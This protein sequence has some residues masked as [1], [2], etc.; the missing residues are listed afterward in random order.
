MI[1]FV[2]H[3]VIV[4]IQMAVIRAIVNLAMKVMVLSVLISM[5]VG[6]VARTDWKTSGPQ[7]RSRLGNPDRRRDDL[8]KCHADYG[9]CTNNV[10]SYE[11]DCISGYTGD[12]IFC[13]DVDE[14]F[15]DTDECDTDVGICHNTQGS[16]YC[17]CPEG[18]TGNGVICNDVDECL[19]VNHDCDAFATCHNDHGVYTCE[20][21]VGYIGNGK[22]CDDVDECITGDH[23]CPLKTI[24][25]NNDGSFNCDCDVGYTS[26]GAD[27]TCDGGNCVGNCVDIDEC[28]L[29]IDTCHDRT[30]CANTD[31][32][33]DFKKSGYIYTASR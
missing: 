4:E 13:D 21:N 26:G 25:S 20:C 19:G 14:C 8:S 24:C 5:S 10:G 3:L 17:S 22:F 28:L 2:I 29:R 15:D 27:E 32:R 12:G 31:G 7:F 18:F 1:I 6:M 33:S 9:I 11:C 23:N 30:E 16:Y